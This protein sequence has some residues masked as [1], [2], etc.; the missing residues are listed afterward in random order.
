MMIAEGACIW[1]DDYLLAHFQY[2]L[3]LDGTE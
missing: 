2:L 1:H 3:R